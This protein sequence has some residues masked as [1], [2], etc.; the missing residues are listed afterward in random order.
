MQHSAADKH[1]V[2]LAC[3]LVVAGHAQLRKTKSIRKFVDKNRPQLRPLIQEL[4]VDKV[5][6]TL[7]T[8]LE[9]GIFQSEARAMT[10]FPEL[11]S[12]EQARKVQYAA[13]QIGVTHCVA[14]PLDDESLLGGEVDILNDRTS[15]QRPEGPPQ[16]SE[17]PGHRL[18][19]PEM[20]AS[21]T[22]DRL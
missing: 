1:K 5:I 10:A 4:G 12:S 18:L 15:V 9:Q 20:Q 3:R 13:N 17:T 6:K 21:K 16:M 19:D 8:L 2:Y 7:K 11:F 22:D 14:G